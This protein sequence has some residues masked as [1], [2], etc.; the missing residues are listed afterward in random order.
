MGRYKQPFSLFKRG[1]YWYY[2]TYTA[3]GVRT[4][5]KTTGLT[6]KN[7]ARLYCEKLN[8]N[9]MLLSNCTTFGEYAAHFFD[10][11]SVYVK[12]RGRPLSKSAIGNYRYSLKCLLAYFGNYKFEDITF[13]AIKNY[14]ASLIDKF[15]TSN[16]NA[17]MNV[18]KL[19]LEHARRD[20]II[21]FNPM[22]D[23][24]A[25]KK[26]ENEYRDAFTLEEIK[27]IY[28]L[29]KLED[30]KKLIVFVA[31]TGLRIGEAIGVCSADIVQGEKTLYIDLKRQWNV[32]EHQFTTLKTE[33]Y[34]QVPIIP[35]LQDYCNWTMSYSYYAR[36]MADLVNI[37]SIQ[38]NLSYHSL[39]HF[40]ITDTKAANI[41]ENKVKYI[42]GHSLG[43]IENIYTHF[44]ADD[45]TEVLDWQRKIFNAIVNQ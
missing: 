18:F 43:A 13:T 23:L 36:H 17:R 30:V 19:I 44:C 41:P 31:C 3:D 1:K 22:D 33:I 7:E 20:R 11:D 15:S 24:T 32:A 14:R 45:C 27:K 28:N 26:K 37:L 8:V 29:M 5:P 9:G 10:D 35:E 12:D 6:S 16:I 38:K 40:F 2:M 4:V 39:R 21:V 34:R 25:L 42:T